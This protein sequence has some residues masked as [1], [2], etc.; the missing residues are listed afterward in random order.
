MG[1]E[2]CPS[3]FFQGKKAPEADFCASENRDSPGE[4]FSV[5]PY[6]PR[7]DRVPPAGGTGASWPFFR[8][9]GCGG[10]M[11]V[12]NFISR[13]SDSNLA[14]FLSC[15]GSSDRRRLG[16]PSR[17][18]G[19]GTLLPRHPPSLRPFAGRAWLRATSPKSGRTGPQ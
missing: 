4:P 13:A 19:N 14:A 11:P 10:R 5:H 8:A 7:V 17:L 18:G 3:P 15:A 12:L 2:I 9:V 1:R 16:K 6:I